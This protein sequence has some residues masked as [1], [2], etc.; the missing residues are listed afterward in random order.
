MCTGAFVLAEAGLLDGRRATTHWRHAATLA[1]RYPAIEVEPDAIYV[2]SGEVLTSAGVSAGIDLSLAMVEQDMGAGLA[3]EV[4]RDLVVFL[5]RPG[6]QSQ[7]SVASRT[8]RPR[9]DPLRGLLDQVAADP[10]AD[11][12]L[13]AMAA[14]AGVSV[15]HLTRL[16]H[17]RV[18]RTPAAYV[19]SVRLEA[20][21]VAPRL[22]RDGH[23]CRRAFGDGQRRV[24]AQGLPPPPGGHPL[25]LPRPVQD[26]ALVTP[27]WREPARPDGTSR[28]A[29]AEP[30]RAAPAETK[31]AGTERPRQS[32]P[33]H[34]RPGQSERARAP[35]RGPFHRPI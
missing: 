24:P 13:Q 5:Q 21:P 22:G 20:A 15:R 28:L 7:F 26:L 1:S 32:R 31:R 11:H 3:R 8:P 9:H 25:G 30:T 35:R 33:G 29:T 4:A 12:S 10:G 23:R 27:S 18:G 19:E 2:R 34:S 14:R 16:F 17:E 6:G